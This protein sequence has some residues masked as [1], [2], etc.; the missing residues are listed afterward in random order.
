MTALKLDKLK[1]IIIINFKYYSV[2]FSKNWLYLIKLCDQSYHNSLRNRVK[3]RMIMK[4]F[5]IIFFSLML[6]KGASFDF[7]VIM[8]N[9][10]TRTLISGTTNSSNVSRKGASNDVVESCHDTCNVFSSDKKIQLTSDTFG[11]LPI[12]F[13]ILNK[14]GSEVLKKVNENNITT[15]FEVPVSK[16]KNGSEIKV[17]NAFGEALLWSKVKI[18]D[19]NTT[20]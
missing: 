3:K 2:Y 15:K 19:K 7:K 9:N 12:T 14:Q 17:T 8:K 5:I 11:P 16:L 13:K 18:I 6:V 20:K 4:I 10:K 1:T